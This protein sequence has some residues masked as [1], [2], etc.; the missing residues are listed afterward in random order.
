MRYCQGS[1]R[2]CLVL[3]CL[4]FSCLESSK[5]EDRIEHTKILGHSVDLL[6]Q[7]PVTAALATLPHLTDRTSCSRFRDEYQRPPIQYLIAHVAPE[8]GGQT[9][10]RRAKTRLQPWRDW[11]RSGEIVMEA[12]E[13][14]G[15]SFGPST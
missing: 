10:P 12:A 8:S 4:A 5:I 2:P 11:P 1:P 13:T 15:K 9:P 14:K 6:S 7:Y 3:S